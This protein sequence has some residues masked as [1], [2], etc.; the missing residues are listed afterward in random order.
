MTM[1]IIFC[2][3]LISLITSN[4]FA[5]T[6]IATNDTIEWKKLE[7]KE[8]TIYYTIDDEAITSV[9][10]DYLRS[11]VKS[12]NDFFGHP[13]L[14]KFDVY[15]FPNRTLLDKQWQKDWNDTSFKS[16]CWMIASGVAH[17]LDVLSPGTWDQ[18]ACD[19]N[20]NDTI[21]IRQVIWHEL[22]HVF[23]GQQNPDHTFNYIEKLDWLVE[24]A[25]TYV[26]GQLTGKRLQRLK[27]MVTENK[28]PATLDNFWKGPDRYGLSGSIVAYI[29]KVYGRKKLFELLRFITKQDALQSLGV[30][31]AKL[32]ADWRNSFY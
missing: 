1:R 28:T 21:E 11:G 10:D 19:H 24:G 32:I 27:Q 7:K 14:K 2:Y 30:T 6:A 17:R 29:D 16:Q 8:F 4:L 23:H 13:F 20:A 9:M 22:V 15:I 25:A 31:E 5:G 3:C 26:S 18:Q 12:I